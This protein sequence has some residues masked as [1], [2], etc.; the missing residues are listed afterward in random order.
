[1]NGGLLCIRLITESGS[2]QHGN[3]NDSQQK[4]IT[5]G[6]GGK[7]SACGDGGIAIVLS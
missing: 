7:V 6:Q 3:P 2:D 1:M 5:P 4:L